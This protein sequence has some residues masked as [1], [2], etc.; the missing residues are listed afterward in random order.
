MNLKYISADEIASNMASVLGDSDFQAIHKK[1][2]FVKKSD[3]EDIKEAVEEFAAEG[4]EDPLEGFD[5]V[6]N[7]DL[8]VLEDDFDVDQSRFED[9]VWQKDEP[10]E[11][12]EELEE[13]VRKY[14]SG[15]ED[16]QQEQIHGEMMNDQRGGP[17]DWAEIAD[18]QK[19]RD[20]DFETEAALKVTKRHLVK[21]ANAL[22]QKGFSGIASI[23][24]NTIV[25]LSEK[26]RTETS[27]LKKAKDDQDYWTDTRGDNDQEENSTYGT[28]LDYFEKE[29]PHL[30]EN[31][32]L[33]LDS[34]LTSSDFLSEAGPYKLSELQDRLMSLNRFLKENS[35][36]MKK[37]RFKALL[38][39]TKQY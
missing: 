31:V 29:V 39:K 16:W 3:D 24:D 10:E 38:K 22:D 28:S 26:K 36:T 23:L 14:D 13:R 25:C 7:E 30:A 27:L 33:N 32:K 5:E 19:D 12:D 4:L 20:I 34:L 17:E 35:G 15:E 1:A 6:P 2:S 8:E 11:T 18:F 21:M 37:E 9:E